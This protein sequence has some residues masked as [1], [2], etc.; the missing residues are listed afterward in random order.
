MGSY[1]QAIGSTL[2]RISTVQRGCPFLLW[3]SSLNGVIT[4]VKENYYATTT[5]QPASAIQEKVVHKM[6]G[7]FINHLCIYPHWTDGIC[8][9]LCNCKL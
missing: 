7:Y 4:L 3:T 5:K 9:G 2:L 6:V 1:A 8:D